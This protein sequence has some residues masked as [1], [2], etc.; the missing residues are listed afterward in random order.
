MFSLLH[1]GTLSAVLSSE[2]SR[3]TTVVVAIFACS[4]SLVVWFLLYD[5]CVGRR[6]KK[7]RIVRQDQ[8]VSNVFPAAI[9]DQLY[10]SGQKGSQDETLFDSLGDGAGTSAGSPFADLFPENTIVTVAKS[11]NYHLERVFF[12]PSRQ[13]VIDVNSK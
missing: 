12:P 9:R 13:D 10:N 8:I 1:L 2:L 4:T 11:W 5:Y 6:A 7:D 3:N